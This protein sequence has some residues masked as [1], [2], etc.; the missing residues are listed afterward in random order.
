LDGVGAFAAAADAHA[1]AVTIARTHAFQPQRIALF[2]TL[3][4][5]MSDAEATPYTL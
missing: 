4:R 3:C 2:S 5:V 1:K